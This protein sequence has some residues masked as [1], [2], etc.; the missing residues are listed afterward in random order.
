MSKRGGES[1][2]IQSLCF[3]DR[4]RCTKASGGAGDMPGTDQSM[5]LLTVGISYTI[6]P[7]NERVLVH[8]RPRIVLLLRK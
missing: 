2:R 3:C 1:S 8:C 4:G 5:Q 6:H 7:D